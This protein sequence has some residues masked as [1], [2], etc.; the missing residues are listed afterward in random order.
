VCGESRI[1]E[2]HPTCLAYAPTNSL[3]HNNNVLHDEAYWL[4]EY[5]DPSNEVVVVLGGMPTGNATK[6]IDVTPFVAMGFFVA[7]IDYPGDCGFL[8]QMKLLFF[9][10]KLCLV[11]KKQKKKVVDLVRIKDLRLQ[12]HCVASNYT[13]NR[14]NQSLVNR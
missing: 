8:S 11:G 4:E 12:R 7:L 3:Y 5:G 10:K 13:S 14:C 2:A 1:A 6:G 9:L